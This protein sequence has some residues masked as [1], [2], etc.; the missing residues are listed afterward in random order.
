MIK[1]LVAIGLA[2]AAFALARS[3][4]QAQMI[5][6]SPSGPALGSTIRGSAATTFSIS[7]SG[8][9]TRSSGDA[10]RMSNTAV[11]TPTVSFNCGLLNLGQLCALRS[12]RV[13]IAPASAG[14]PA[15]IS[16]F[17]IASL[18][19][20]TYVS[21][22]PPS[23]GATLVFDLNPLGLLSTVT[24]KLGMDILLTANAASGPAT[25]SYTVTV[26]FI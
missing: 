2:M 7:T 20:T 12:V 16:R 25:F 14:A 13:T 6:L 4:A 17:R 15:S 10:I 9:V 8:V 11:S 1:V 19:G 21:G 18:S 3:P 23:E 5:S 24:F 22:S 26:V